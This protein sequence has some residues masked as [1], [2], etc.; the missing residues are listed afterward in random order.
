MYAGLY[1]DASELC[2]E[3]RQQFVGWGQQDFAQ[4]IKE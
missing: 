1:L 4:P 2:D 3:G